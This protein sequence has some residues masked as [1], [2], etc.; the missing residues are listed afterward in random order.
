MKGKYVI[1][2]LLILFSACATQNYLPGNENENHTILLTAPQNGL[3]PYPWDLYT[4]ANNYTPTLMQLK[5]PLTRANDP[6]LQKYGDPIP[7]LNELTGFSLNGPIVL[8]FSKGIDPDIIK[9]LASTRC[10]E[11][12]NGVF[13]LNLHTGNTIPL[14]PKFFYGKNY[15]FLFPHYP[16]SPATTYALVLSNNLKGID[17]SSVVPDNFYIKISRGECSHCSRVVKETNL[18]KNIIWKRYNS[19][20]TIAII[21]FTTMSIMQ[22]YLAGKRE[23]INDSKKEK[24]A[25]TFTSNIIDYYPNYSSNT[26]LVIKGKLRVVKLRNSDGEIQFD[27][28]NGTFKNISYEEIPYLLLFPS[29]GKEPF[30][31]MIYQHGLNNRKESVFSIADQFNKKGI[32]IIAIDIVYHGE[33][34]PAPGNEM[35]LVKNFLGIWPEN[36]ILKIRPYLLRDEIIQTVFNQLQLIEFLK[37]ISILDVYNLSTKNF[38]SDGIKDLKGPPYGYQGQSLGGF[39]G[40][41]TTSISS[42]IGASIL[43]VTGGRISCVVEENRFFKAGGENLLTYFD[44]LHPSEGERYLA[45]FQNI[46]DPADPGSFGPIL[47]GKRKGPR[48]SPVNLLMENVWNDGIVPNKCTAYFARGVG[49]P[50]LPPVFFPIDGIIQ[51]K[52]KEV[53]GNIDKIYTAALSQ[54]HMIYLKT[55]PIAATHSTLLGAPEA[56]KEGSSFLASYFAGI[57]NSTPPQIISPY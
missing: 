44:T 50:L 8:K 3:I 16:L 53:R 28:K 17:G 48:G 4:I 13:L 10:T 21:P 24:Y 15:L 18:A 7:Y 49:I 33:R 20:K 35:D 54:Y 14:D 51:L 9:K 57:T 23:I 22:P 26:G 19:I 6:I 2:I 34:S 42:D 32:A 31:V 45:L 47:L 25:E 39:I 36:G 40:T 5:I 43:N 27:Y 52:S 30:P 37:Q 56:Q 41:I 55:K 11:P 1:A 29:H 38:G 12:T 46:I